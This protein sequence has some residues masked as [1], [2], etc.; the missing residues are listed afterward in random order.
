MKDIVIRVYLMTHREPSRNV[1]TGQS[2][3]KVI[4]LQ[5]IAFNL[6]DKVISE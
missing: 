3:S 5:S 6:L 2:F 4:W 1:Q